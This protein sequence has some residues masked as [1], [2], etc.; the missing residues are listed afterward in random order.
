MSP[1]T[2]RRNATGGALEG[3]FTTIVRG[4]SV[5]SALLDDGVPVSPK[6]RSGFS[7]LGPLAKAPRLRVGL[8]LVA[9]HS[10]LVLIAQEQV[11]LIF[12]ALRPTLRGINAVSVNVGK[13]SFW[14]NCPE[15]ISKD[16]GR[17]MLE[18][19]YAPWPKR[20]PP[21]FEVEPSGVRTY[22]VLRA[23]V[24]TR[25]RIAAFCPNPSSCTDARQRYDNR[26]YHGAHEPAN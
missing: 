5:M 24:A 2:A 9:A 3:S 7:P 15:L 25:S 12:R 11:R 18:A 21:E 26:T 14:K 22:R 20:R 1:L 10:R 19:G 16:I 17:W 4:V 13:S 8:I 6:A 23:R